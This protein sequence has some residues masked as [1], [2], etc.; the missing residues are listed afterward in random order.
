MSSKPTLLITGASGMLAKRLET[1]FQKDYQLKFLT[2]TP[3]RRNDFFWD[4][5]KKLISKE[6][7]EEVEHILHLAGASIGEKR[8]TKKRKKE[9]SDSRVQSAQLLLEEIKKRNIRLKTYISASAVGYYG[10]VTS[11]KT[12]KETSP[13]G[14]DFLAKVCQQW[15]QVANEFE[16]VSDRI[17]ILRF[18][19]IISKDGG[20]LKKIFPLVK[21]GLNTIMGTGKQ[22]MP[23][24]DID[25]LASMIVFSFEKPNIYG[26][27]NAVSPNSINQKTF[28][29]VLA[30][31]L[32]QNVWLPP[33]PKWFLKI[34]IGESS[35]LVLEGSQVS[36]DKIINEGFVFQYD[37][38]EK[39]LNK[40]L[41]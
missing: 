36:C 31:T 13:P 23:W 4:P 20:V 17:V 2:R 41:K 14:N 21:W 16:A 25:D 18:G 11:N 34:V 30:K 27:Y 9:I 6:A 10:T 26:V 28:I 3:K 7:F 29:Q 12:F 33:I 38:I 39:S 40:E 15:E 37:S 22:I 5:E 1:Y 35:V 24:I 32:G 19:V 8:W